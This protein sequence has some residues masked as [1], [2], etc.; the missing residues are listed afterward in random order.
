MKISGSVTIGDTTSGDTVNSVIAA[1]K[2]SD[3]S[4]GGGKSYF[5]KDGSGWLAD[6][7]ISWDS[8]G[9]MSIT[10]NIG[11]K[12]KTTWNG[13]E[14]N[15]DKGVFRM[16]GPTTVEDGNNDIPGPSADEVDLFKI[17]YEID[18]D[19]LGRI[20]TMYFINPGYF[21]LRLDPIDG[22][23]FLRR[24]DDG[25]IENGWWI[26]TDGMYFYK[27]GETHEVLTNMIIK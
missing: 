9:T 25:R 16:Y 24:Y 18:Q 21:E 5:G 14:L 6:N 22:I 26:Q 7:S 4:I 27:N 8:G 10:G 19:T 11:N 12:N 20:A 1:L 23:S 15:T 17:C 3:I 2:T 13:F